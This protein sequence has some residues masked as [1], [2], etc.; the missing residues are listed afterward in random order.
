M[1]VGEK[2]ILYM[3]VI[4][5]VLF[6]IL[7]WYLRKKEKKEFLARQSANQ[8]KEAVS[9]RSVT[10]SFI[11]TQPEIRRLQLQAY[12]RCIIL[13][14]RLGFPALL[15]KNNYR[16]M[17]AGQLKNVL[18]QDIKNEFEYNLS[19]QLYVSPAAWDALARFK[20]QQVFILNQITGLLPEQAAGQDLAGKIM[21]LLTLDENASLQPIVASLLRKEARL[22]MQ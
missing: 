19:Q 1:M 21:E 10:P 20:E 15:G 14:E 12:E 9:E 13:C 8:Q 6:T 22:L 18:T 11:S 4:A 2:E 16:E 7:G 17:T 5:A 3:V